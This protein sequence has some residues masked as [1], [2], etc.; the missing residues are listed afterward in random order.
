MVN[1]MLIDKSLLDVLL[2]QAKTTEKLRKNFDLRTSPDDNS[3][4][5]LNAMIPGTV[6]PIHRHQQTTEVV[7]CLSGRFDEVFY[8]DNGN[9]TT[10]L[11]LCPTE[12]NYGCQVPQGMWHTVDVLEPSVIFE[13]KD[14]PFAPLEKEDVMIL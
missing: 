14:G 3:Q 4:R 10:R 13:A 1:D 6:V 12:G 7:I 5:M 2:E 9:E 11:R 8:D